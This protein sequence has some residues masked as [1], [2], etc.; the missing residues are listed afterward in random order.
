MACSKVSII[1]PAYNAQDT[2]ENAIRSVLAQT[3]GEWELLILDDASTDAT[4]AVVKTFQEDPRVQFFPSS[5]NRGVAAT[6]NEGIEKST[7][8]WI[9]FLDSDDTWA[10]DK[11]EKQLLRLQEADASLCYTSYALVDLNGKKV[12]GDY[13]V[14]ETVDYSAL[15]RENVIGCST[16]LVEASVVKAH[17]FEPGFYHEDYVLWCKLLKAG[18]RAVGCPE[19]LMNWCY[20]E[21]SRSY[22]KFKSL[23]KRWEI[24]RKALQLPL[25]T[26]AANIMS[27]AFAGMKKYRS[28]PE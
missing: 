7:G 17:P 10:P 16:V 3:I 14:P 25:W 28:S 22:N 23:Q 15:L 11:L 2:I 5:V 6:R 8:Q 26:S 27:Y 18:Y 21:N 12:R 20:R 24:Y 1:L 4:E 19:V 9:A 13:M